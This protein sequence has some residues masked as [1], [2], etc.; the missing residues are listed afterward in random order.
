MD[1]D[2]IS[3]ESTA[4]CKRWWKVCRKQ[5]PK[6]TRVADLRKQVLHWRQ[7]LVDNPH[8]Q[9]QIDTGGTHTCMHARALTQAHTHAFT[10]ARTRA[11]G[12]K[13][14][15]WRLQKKAI[16]EADKRVRNIVYPHGTNG[17]SKDGASFFKGSLWRTAE[18]LTAL[19]IILTTSIRD[20]IPA[21]RTGLRKLIWG[22][23]ILEGRCVNANEAIHVN[24]QPGKLHPLIHTNTKPPLTNT[25]EHQQVA[26]PSRTRTSQKPK[27]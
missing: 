19:L 24:V 2:T 6:G 26:D 13:P 4:W 23:R 12:S 16:D 25:H 21:V 1:P 18:K 5:V 17:C 10:R 3:H 22:L 27:S 15:P 14:L 8:Q 7:F 9:L 20:Y 11:S